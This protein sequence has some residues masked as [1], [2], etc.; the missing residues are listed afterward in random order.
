MKLF[1]H[2]GKHVEFWTITG[3]VLGSDKYSETHVTSSGGGGH[4]SG[5]VGPNGGTVSGRVDTPMVS[6]RSVTNHDFWIKTDNGQ[7]KDIQLR[8]VDIPLRVGQKI[9][10]V[11]AGLKGRNKRWYAML[12]NHNAG[13]RWII[14]RPEELNQKLNLEKMTGKSLIAG[15]AVGAGGA[16]LVGD[17]IIRIGQYGIHTYLIP[18]VGAIFFVIYRFFVKQTRFS[19]L[20]KQLREHLEKLAALAYAK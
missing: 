9:T 17:D 10:L 19:R 4:V 11:S 8:G 15:I 12:V 7:E 5:Y 20:I 3:E 16:Y 1:S 13:K 6:S 2:R 14:N 18:I